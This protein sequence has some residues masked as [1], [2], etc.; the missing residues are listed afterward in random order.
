MESKFPTELLVQSRKVYLCK[1][2]HIHNHK[3]ITTRAVTGDRV[4]TKYEMITEAQAT[5]AVYMLLW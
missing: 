3:Y 1:D 4:E 5:P 2:T